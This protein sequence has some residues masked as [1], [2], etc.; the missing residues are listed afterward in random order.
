MLFK[1]RFRTGKSLIRLG[2]SVGNF[3]SFS[4]M[5]KLF[6]SNGHRRFG[7]RKGIEKPLFHKRPPNEESEIPF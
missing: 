6:D 1:D 7:L 5:R 3:M 2:T 4:K